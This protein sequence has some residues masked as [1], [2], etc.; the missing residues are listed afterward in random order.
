MPDQRAM[1]DRRGDAGP[2]P[3]TLRVIGC[4][5]QREVD[6]AQDCDSLRSSH[7]GDRPRRAGRD[8]RELAA[9]EERLERAEEAWLELADQIEAR[10]LEI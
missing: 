3:S 10:G 1:P 8:R 5:A 2:S 4:A 9:A 6:Q 7:R